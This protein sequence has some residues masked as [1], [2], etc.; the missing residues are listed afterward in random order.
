MIHL[1]A[2]T[3]AV[4]ITIASAVASRQFWK[5]YD[6][7]RLQ[8]LS[9]FRGIKKFQLFG[10]VGLLLLI[11]SGITMLSLYD[12]AYGEQLW[13]RI[14]MSCILLIL[15]NGFTFGRMTTVRMGKLLARDGHANGAEVGVLRLKRNQSIFL[16]TQLSLFFVIIVMSSFRFA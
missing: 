4:G 15:V 9:A 7:D 5:L 12:W 14:K 13:F 11:L 8:G 6:S 3:M 2:L 10:M 1:I 16:A